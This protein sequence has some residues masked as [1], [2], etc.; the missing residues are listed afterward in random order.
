MHQTNLYQNVMSMKVDD[1]YVTSNVED[2][3]FAEAFSALSSFV[4]G[5]NNQVNACVVV[6][7]NQFSILV[8][9]DLHNIW[10]A[11][12]ARLTSKTAR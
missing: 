3:S 7:T 11:K 10:T 1:S 5:G 2:M 8:G 12:T 9:K 6:A 4:P